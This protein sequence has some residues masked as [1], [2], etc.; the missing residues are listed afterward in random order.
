MDRSDTYQ[1]PLNS[2]PLTF[3]FADLV[4]GEGVAA[5]RLPPGAVVV[6]GS[7]VVQTAWDS[8]TSATIDVGDSD[9][10][11]RY[12]S[13]PVDLT[14]TG[15]TALT[16]TGHKYANPDDLQLLLA[17]DGTAATEGEGYIEVE[18]VMEGRV[19]EPVT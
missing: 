1:W 5:L 16:L 10:D 3:T 11:D 2:G 15:R 13:S 17:E 6:G 7:I 19:S 4:D 9:D 14:T 8:G 18:I 12:T